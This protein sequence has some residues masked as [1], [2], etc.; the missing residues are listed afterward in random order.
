MDIGIIGA[1]RIG[2]H[3]AR[4]LRGI[5]A[6]GTLRVF[7][8]VESSAATLA[9]EVA[10]TAATSL[11]EVFGQ[12]DAIVIASATDTHADMLERAAA[13]G[14][15]TFC[16]KPISLTLERT[17]EAV[18]RVDASGIPV[19]MGFQRRYD[20]A[21][22]PIADRIA[23]G[24]LA[25]PYLVRSQTHDPE[26]PPPGYIPHSGGMFTDCLIHDIDIVRFVT[27][28]E[29]ATVHAVGTTTGHPEIGELGDH[30][31]VAALFV[32]DG[33][34]IAQLSGL[35]RDPVGY[36]VRLEVFTETE[37]LGAGW[38]E[39]SP[40]VSSEPGVEPPTDPI[41]SFWDR[42][43]D[44]YQIEMEAFVEV[45]EGRATPASDH[46]D[47]YQDLRVAVACERSAR[48]GR[49]VPLEEVPA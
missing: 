32:M 25:T 3:H 34:T 26:P 20:P 23:S 19:Q 36:D 8:V 35:R 39:R 2:S 43:A 41:L 7:D 21:M 40:I 37:A 10:D 15:A 16:E 45:V 18:R 9:E 31:N 42:F 29:V 12:S 47:A 30:A 24:D 13:A 6:V 27:G 11:D 46:H 38:S 48:E 14:L 28:Q 33:G 49:A 22:R 44:A 1:G 4:V 17:K 5:S